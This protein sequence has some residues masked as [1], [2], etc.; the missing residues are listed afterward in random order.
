VHAAF[1][2]SAPYSTVCDALV[3]LESGTNCFEFRAREVYW[4]MRGKVSTSLLFRR[5]NVA[6]AMKSV[7][8]T[9]RN[10]KSLQKLLP[11]LDLE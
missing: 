9:T 3:A 10:I 4:L 7:P 2:H 8:H 11:K 5:N 6:K 1:T